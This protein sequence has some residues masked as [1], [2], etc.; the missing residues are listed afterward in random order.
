MP[1]F[2][3]ISALMTIISGC[4]PSSSS[5]QTAKKQAGLSSPEKPSTETESASPDAL[6][7]TATKVEVHEYRALLNMVGS[8]YYDANKKR[9]LVL[10]ARGSDSIA[11]E[12]V[13]FTREFN[14]QC[15]NIES[16]LKG[17]DFYTRISPPIESL[18]RMVEA[19]TDNDRNAYSEAR[20]AYGKEILDLRKFVEDAELTLKESQP[21]NGENN[22]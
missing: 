13:E 22:N 9:L 16:Q 5:S 20:V 2:I 11:D 14:E 21:A 10:K 3:L 7:T 8:L 18:K 15:A 17:K 19:I 12:W 4:E 6:S 1:K